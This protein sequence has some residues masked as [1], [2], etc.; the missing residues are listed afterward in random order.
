MTQRLFSHID[1][2]V[3]DGV[4]ALAFYDVLLKEFG[5]SRVEQFTKAEPVWRRAKWQ[6]NDEFFG[7]VVDPH[8]VP[9]H[10]RIAFHGSSFDHVDRVTAALRNID[11]PELDGPQNYGGSYYATFFN[12]PDGNRLEVCFLI[13]H[14]GVAGDDDQST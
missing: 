13:K 2:R 14:G 12:D 6:A 10:N 9:N 7:F 11:A 3:R 5:F 4:R 1:L 8:F